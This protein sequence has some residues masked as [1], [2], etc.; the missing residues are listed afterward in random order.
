MG[1]QGAWDGSSKC[2]NRRQF[3]V[4]QRWCC[5]RWTLSLDLLLLLFLEYLNFGGRL[6]MMRLHDYKSNFFI[7]HVVSITDFLTCPLSRLAL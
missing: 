2:W 3:D 4:Q 5:F 6:V 1:N 7:L